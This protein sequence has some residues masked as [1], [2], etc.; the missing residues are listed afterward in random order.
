[1]VL[2]GLTAL[3]Y[4]WRKHKVKP[5]LFALGSILWFITITLKAVMDLL[6]TTSIYDFLNNTIQPASL[7]I[8]SLMI[9]LRTGFF[10]SGISYLVLKLKIKKIKWAESIAIGIG[11]GAS[12]AIVL[13][14][15]SLLSMSLL[16]NPAFTAELTEVEQ[17]AIESLFNQNTLIIFAS[18]IERIFILFVHVFATIL[19]IKA[20]KTKKLK[21]LWL[22]I[23]FKTIVDFP[24]PYFQLLV[25]NANLLNVY[26]TQL[27][28]A[29][30]GLAALYG[31]KRLKK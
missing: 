25:S 1:M 6:L 28:I 18:W 12:E 24:V 8:L 23:G 17:A 21:Y 4:W 15:L 10:E 29:G 30:V 19:V 3:I 13:G 5:Q 11:F 26:L 20:I 22:S 7:F 27:Y 2:I 14:S 16:M 9:G 31:L